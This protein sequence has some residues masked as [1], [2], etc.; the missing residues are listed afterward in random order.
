MT[1][2]GPILGIEH[3]DTHPGPSV[4]APPAARRAQ[5]NLKHSNGIFCVLATIPPAS[6]F[7]LSTLAA[8]LFSA[9]AMPHAI[10]NDGCQREAFLI[11]ST[12]S[13]PY[14]D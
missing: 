4:T 8:F 13:D 11:G 6:F 12:S 7:F 9:L 5:H 2:I 1:L 14:H 3:H 10:V